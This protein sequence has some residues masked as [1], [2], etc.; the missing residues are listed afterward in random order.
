[1]F[2]SEPLS[3]RNRGR[4]RFWGA[5]F[6]EG[7]RGRSESGHAS[8]GD[9]EVEEGGADAVWAK[10][11]LGKVAIGEASEDGHADGGVRFVVGADSEFNDSKVLGSASSIAATRNDPGAVH[12][13]ADRDSETQAGIF[14]NVRR[15]WRKVQNGGGSGEGAVGCEGQKSFATK[16]PGS[17]EASTVLRHG[18]GQSEWSPRAG[19][20]S[21]VCGDPADGERQD[22]PSGPQY[23]MRQ[24]YTLE[25]DRGAGGGRIGGG[26]GY[27]V[28][29]WAGHPQPPGGHRRSGSGAVP[30][31]GGG[32]RW[33]G[34]N[35]E[36]P[37]GG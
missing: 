8:I 22:F 1:M 30:A 33:Q 29:R 32:W 15:W 26:V 25:G 9:H 36:S 10:N 11:G 34:G 5:G 4:K 18:K 16:A 2:P 17:N 27:G 19:A 7:L 28:E 13:K 24:E 23:P 20:E 35:V 14:G 12:D 6:W 3:S 37:M 31:E 21:M